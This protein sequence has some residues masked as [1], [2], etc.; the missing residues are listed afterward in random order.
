MIKKIF[1][2]LIVL[3]LITGCSKKQQVTNPFDN[4]QQ[5]QFPTDNIHFPNGNNQ[6]GGP[7][8]NN[9]EFNGG[10]NSGQVTVNTLEAIDDTN[11][12][13]N[14]DLN[15]NP[16]LSQAIKVTVSDSGEYII[17]KEG[18]YVFT[19]EAKNY[20]IKVETDKNEKVQIVL[21]SLTV[22]N[23][24]FPVIYVKATDKCFITS[25]NNNSLSVTNKFVSDGDI[26]TDA[27]IFSKDDLT[28]NGTGS[29]QIISSAG[30]GISCKDDFKI[31]SGSYDIKSALDSIEANDSI[32][33]YDGQFIIETNK[34]GLHC[35]DDQQG[36]IYIKNGN[37][38]I[39]SK[40]DGIQATTYLSIN[41]G[42]FDIKAVEGLEA[43]YVQ[44]NDGLISIKASDDGINASK[45]SNELDVV[46]EINGGDITVVMAS[47]DTDG[48]DA[49]GT[50]IVNGGTIDV[51]GV[52][53]FDAD[54]GSIYNGGTIIINGQQVDSI[55]SGNNFGHGGYNKNGFGKGNR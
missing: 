15:S 9:P 25:L 22:T 50:I 49:N 51:S 27:V 48:L 20:T 52:S 33:I 23:D 42:C 32:C 40:D 17:E 44:I 16:D 11:M 30:N 2:I 47:G 34:D 18:I 46:I 6:P 10:Y 45:K 53:T 8:G 14:R 24:N 3:L 19:G 37:F 38:V 28:L 31:T 13:S 5:N 39:N 54:N 55:P 43:T 4:N 41:G 26:N 35:E 7:M 36:S 1:I 21:D 29:L 12:F